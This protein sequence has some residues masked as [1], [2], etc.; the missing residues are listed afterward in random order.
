MLY[1]QY[2]LV[3]TLL[4]LAVFNG[5]ILQDIFPNVLFKSICGETPDIDDVRQM[6]PVRTSSILYKY[7]ASRFLTAC[8]IYNTNAACC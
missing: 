1:L 4:G 8:L 6:K 3:G 5:V 2:E 7:D